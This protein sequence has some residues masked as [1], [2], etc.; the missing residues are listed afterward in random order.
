[1]CKLCKKIIE[2]DKEIKGS[3][4]GKYVC[5]FGV[6]IGYSIH[7]VETGHSIPIYHDLV[8][9]GKLKYCPQCGEKLNDVASFVY[10]K[11][12]DDLEDKWT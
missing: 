8:L 5:D 3:D 2:F 11:K 1:M 7:E 9:E 6:R 10:D 4:G 12:Q